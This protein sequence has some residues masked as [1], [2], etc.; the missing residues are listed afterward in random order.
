MLAKESIFTQGSINRTYTFS[1]SVHIFHVV[2]TCEFSFCYKTLIFFVKFQISTYHKKIHLKFF[3][4]SVVL[5]QNW[6]HF[7]SSKGNNSDKNFIKMLNLRIKSGICER[8]IKQSSK[9][10]FWFSGPNQ[11]LEFIFTGIY[12]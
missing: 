10:K 3:V 4:R 1:W 12:F 7:A 11:I 5:A 9:W 8:S 6:Y 2:I